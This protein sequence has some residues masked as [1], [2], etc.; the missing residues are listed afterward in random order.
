MIDYEDIHRVV[1]SQYRIRK[2]NHILSKFYHLEGI[3][4]TFGE[5][6]YLSRMG[7]DYHLFTH[8]INDVR[9]GW[10]FKIDK[11][12]MDKFRIEVEDAILSRNTYIPEGYT[13]MDI[14]FWIE[15]YFLFILLNQIGEPKETMLQLHPLI[16]FY[17][18]ELSL[19]SHSKA[20][21]FNIMGD[22]AT[23]VEL[24]GYYVYRYNDDNSDWGSQNKSCPRYA[25]IKVGLMGKSYI[26]RPE[27]SNDNPI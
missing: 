12:S 7:E 17:L 8:A 2:A 1:L 20:L 13:P 23:P 6:V 10:C 25:Q 4:D 19:G 26:W 24:I 11:D 14:F 15:K 21:L 27:I 18:S 9:N 5:I 3:P 16:A 22:E